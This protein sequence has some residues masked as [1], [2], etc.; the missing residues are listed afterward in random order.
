MKKPAVRV[1]PV[2]LRVLTECTTAEIPRDRG[3]IQV[4]PWDL[5]RFDTSEETPALDDI[6]VPED[7]KEPEVKTLIGC[8]C[9]HYIT[10]Q[11]QETRREME[12]FM[13]TFDAGESIVIV[14]MEMGER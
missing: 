2:E 10:G 3:G 12:A 13:Q 8:F 7:E 5:L 9:P 14:E 1:K 11:L 6:D 4:V